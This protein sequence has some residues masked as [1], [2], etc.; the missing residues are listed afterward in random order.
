MKRIGMLLAVLA[1]AVIAVPASHAATINFSLDTYCDY[2]TITYAGGTTA[3][4]YGY[5][6]NYDCT[7]VEGIGGYLHTLPKADLGPSKVLDMSD[8]VFALAGL[9]DSTN[10]LF[11]VPKGG[12]GTWAF[13]FS[14]GTGQYLGNEGT[15]TET[16]K[17]VHGKGMK[18][19]SRR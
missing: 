8:E 4:L 1:L 9:A 19:A 12:V 7:N 5:H 6:Y 10:W 14:D 15:Y 18:P 13:Y 11:S 16:S 3:A 17:G 2:Y